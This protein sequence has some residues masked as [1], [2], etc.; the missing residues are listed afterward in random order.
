MR[1][2]FVRVLAPI[3]FCLAVGVSVGARAEPDWSRFRGPNGSGISTATGMPIEFGPQKNLLWRLALPGGHSSPILHGDRIY[4]TA[5]RGDTLVTIAI[6]RLKGSIL[7]ERSAPQVKTKI[8]DKRNNPA[9]PSPA[10][11]DN[12]VYVFFPD[13][14]LIAYDA[15]GEGALVDAAR[16]VQQHLRHGRLAGDRRRPG[17]PRLRPE[18]RLVHH[19]REQAHRPRAVEGRS[20]RSQERSLDADRLARTRR[21]GS[22]PRARIVSAHGLR[23]GDRPEAVVGGR[24]VVRDEV[25]AG[26]RRR[27]D[28][29]QRLRR[30]GQRSR[31]QGQRAARRRG[32]EDGRRRRQRDALEDRVSEVHRSVLVRRRRSR[33][34]RLAD[35]RTSGRTTAPRSIRRTACSP[36]ASAARAT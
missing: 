36:S 27:H 16:P 1:S 28:L 34:E 25:D 9:S 31:Q 14:G 13:Y 20:A 6:D 10:V 30:A 2:V 17:D 3:L 33:R 22:D 18:P 35:A 26:H 4:L 11:E 19:G 21:Q 5:F 8:V 15:R 29:R 12:G 32:L 7:W 24:P 23:C